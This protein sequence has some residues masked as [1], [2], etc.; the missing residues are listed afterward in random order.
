MSLQGFAKIIRQRVD[1][2]Q[3]KLELATQKLEAA[4]AAIATQLT[5]N[6]P[7]DLSIP[8]IDTRSETLSFETYSNSWFEE[9]QDQKVQYGAELLF[10]SNEGNTIRGGQLNITIP[11]G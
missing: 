1:S 3:A 6:P 9:N 7:L 11:L 2:A 10:D 5:F 8:V 4:P